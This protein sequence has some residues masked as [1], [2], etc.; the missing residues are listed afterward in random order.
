MLT[1]FPKSS[2][3]E[4]AANTLICLIHQTNFLLDQQLRQLE[5]AFVQEGGLRER[6][7][8]A[9]LTERAKGSRP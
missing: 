2:D 7:T 9:R 1:P 6:M 3:P 4:T 8:R 5:T